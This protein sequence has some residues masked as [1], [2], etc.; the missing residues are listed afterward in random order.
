MEID[1]HIN[2]LKETLLWVHSTV[3]FEENAEILSFHE[4]VK[5]QWLLHLIND[6]SQEY[7]SDFQE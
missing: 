6:S 4:C 3:G 1:F 7:F 2:I 5:K